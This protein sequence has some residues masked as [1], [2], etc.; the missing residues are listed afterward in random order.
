M[1]AAKKLKKGEV[2]IVLMV[3]DEKRMLTVAIR[4]P[5]PQKVEKEEDKVAHN[6]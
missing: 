4:R 2:G 5:A 3:I 1:A 6:K